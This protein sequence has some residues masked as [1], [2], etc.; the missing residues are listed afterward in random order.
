MDSKTYTAA[1]N[2]LRLSSEIR[3]FPISGL[4]TILDHQD[5]T[6]TVKFDHQLS[7][8]EET[9]LD[10][11]VAAHS[12]T[13]LSVP[14][15]E[16]LTKQGS[17]DFREIDY[18]ILPQALHPVRTF[19]QGE[20]VMV[21]WYTDDTLATKV[22]KVEITYN[23]DAF[24][25]VLDRVT[26][27]TWI[28]SDGSENPKK[29]VRAKHYDSVKQQSEIK[30]RRENN[31]LNIQANTLSYMVATMTGTV[32]EILDQGRAFLAELD[33]EVDKYIKSGADDLRTAILNDTTEAWLDNIVPGDVIT[34]R[35]YMTTELVI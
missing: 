28:N 2:L 16:S 21:E 25:Y 27:R 9:D 10:S 19:D 20:L 24:G 12:A 6:F 5:G 15:I 3:D 4:E 30:K 18:T 13:P 33:S 22:L 1:V 7:T 29:S 11:I 8:Q 26:T 31:I 17:N 23:R 14:V 32:T 34:I 35:D